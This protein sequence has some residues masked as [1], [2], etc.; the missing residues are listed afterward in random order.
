MF[1]T[2]IEALIDS[3]QQLN[4]HSIEQGIVQALA[5]TILQM[6]NDL[7]TQIYTSTTNPAQNTYSF[8][9]S[10]PDY[11]YQHPEIDELFTKRLKGVNKAG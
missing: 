10:I 1:T 3:L 7:I 6:C 4:A 11:L 5:R 2:A 9:K 8:D